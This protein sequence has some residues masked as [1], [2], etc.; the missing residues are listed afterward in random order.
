MGIRHHLRKSWVSKEIAMPDQTSI[1]TSGINWTQV[2]EKLP[3]TA[4]PHL[5]EVQRAYEGGRE[6]SA[7][8][9][10]LAL[11]EK[12]AGLRRRFEALKQEGGK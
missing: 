1:A 6:N 8:A 12:V 2:K 3:K 11:R 9:V 4:W 5:E 10:E 7:R